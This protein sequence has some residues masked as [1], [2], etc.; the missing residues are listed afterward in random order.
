[1]S[2][3]QSLEN[4]LDAL[5]LIG[6]TVR[7][8]KRKDE[9]KKLDGRIWGPAT[10]GFELSIQA[11]PS[12]AKAGVPIH[13][14]L[15]LRNTSDAD[16]QTTIADWLAFYEVI[17]TGPDG[18]RLEITPYGQRILAVHPDMRQN[19]MFP[20]G[21]SIHNELPIS[22]LYDMSR[23]GKYLVR[24]MCPVPGTETNA[25][26]ESNDVEVTRID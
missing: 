13:L 15:A 22:D 16:V 4:F 5:G 18:T 11:R 17:A 19:A 21:N 14:A 20:A 25:K 6:F 8:D 9:W 23:P 7:G 26:C 2:F 3:R 1:M 24:A 12:A 10:A